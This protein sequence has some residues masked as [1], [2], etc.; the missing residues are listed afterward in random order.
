MLD[1]L[2]LEKLAFQV[3]VRV[4]VVDSLY[5]DMLTAARVEEADEDLSTETK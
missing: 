4:D 3:D 2:V 5:V 1:A